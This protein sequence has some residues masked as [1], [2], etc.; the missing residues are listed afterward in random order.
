MSKLKDYYDGYWNRRLNTEEISK[1][2]ISRAKFVAELLPYKDLGK[3]LDIGCGDGTLLYVLSKRYDFSLDPYGIEISKKAGNAA[4]GRGI[5]VYIGSAESEFPYEDDFFDTVICSEVLE[6]LI[7]PDRALSE[8]GR[9]AKRDATIIFSVPNIGYIKN[10]IKLLLGKSPFEQ[11][12]YSSIEHL[13]FWTKESFERLV[14]SN[15]FAVVK[16]SGGYGPKIGRFSHQYPSLLSDT[17][18]MKAKKK[19]V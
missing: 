6:H 12:R 7:S 15:G 18:Y 9:I 13:H 11:G 2:T 14:I 16:V 10:R 3:T 1:V 8:I 17:L 19:I 4:T 5:N